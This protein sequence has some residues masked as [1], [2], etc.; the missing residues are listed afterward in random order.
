MEKSG[1]KSGKM[2]LTIMSNEDMTG[3]LTHVIAGFRHAG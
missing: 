1:Q 3:A 2:N